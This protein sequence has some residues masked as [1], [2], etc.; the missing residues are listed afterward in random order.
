LQMVVLSSSSR[1]PTTRY[2]QSSSSNTATVV[3]GRIV[4]N[5]SSL[6]KPISFSSLRCFVIL[7]VLFY[8]HATNPANFYYM[9]TNSSSPST[10]KQPKAKMKQQQHLNPKSRTI[11]TWEQ[12]LLL[13]NTLFAYTQWTYPIEKPSFTSYVDYRRRT[14]NYWLFNVQERT[15]KGATINIGGIDFECSYD[16]TEHPLIGISICQNII[17]QYMTH[18]KPLFYN[19]NDYSYTSYRCIAWVLIISSIISFCFTHPVIFY[20]GYT[21]LDS[22]STFVY[23]YSDQSIIISLIYR[24][25]SLNLLIYPVL[26]AMETTVKQQ[27]SESLFVLSSTNYS[28]NYC[29]S[30]LIWLSLAIITNAASKSWTGQYIL[31]FHALTAV[32]M[33]YYSRYQANGMAPILDWMLE[34]EEADDAWT[35]IT[36]TIVLILA[37]RNSFATAIFWCLAHCA[38]QMLYQYQYD[39]LILIATARSFA[40]WINSVSRSIEHMLFGKSQYPPKTVYR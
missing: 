20:T 19:Y 16:D 4:Y 24:L 3:G 26:Q 28:I 37:I 31:Q 29:F 12:F 22:F 27:S 14:T 6:S 7:S 36:W 15:H 13:G 11:T 9:N 32:G 25:L 21:L 18:R 10:V 30:L 35:F 5:N 40:N 38:G 8:L 17:Q 1:S 39:H 23:E 33:G 2:V 34:P